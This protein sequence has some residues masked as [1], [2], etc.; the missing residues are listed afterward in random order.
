MNQKYVLSSYLLESKMYILQVSK[1]IDQVS[2]GYLNMP[3]NVHNISDEVF[4]GILVGD[5]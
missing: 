5:R 4:P 1:N 2:S 3:L